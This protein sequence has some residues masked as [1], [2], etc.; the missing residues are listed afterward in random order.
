M[1]AFNEQAEKFFPMIEVGSVI[2]LSKAGLQHK[3]PVSWLR[4]G[5]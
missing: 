5:W 2:M 4:E 3:K 1:T